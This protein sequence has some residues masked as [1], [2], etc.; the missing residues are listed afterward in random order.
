MAIAEGKN[1]EA[2]EM[3]HP[4]FVVDYKIKHIVKP[5]PEQASHIVFCGTSIS[6]KSS[7]MTSLSFSTPPSASH[8]PDKRHVEIKHPYEL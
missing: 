7:L 2:P 4:R 3:K 5:F 6:G 1:T 8:T